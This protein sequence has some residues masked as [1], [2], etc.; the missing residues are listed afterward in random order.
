MA[1]KSHVVDIGD[2]DLL[3]PWSTVF[4]IAG[5]IDIADWVLVGGLMVQVHAYRAGMTLPRATKDL[6]LVVNVASLAIRLWSDRTAGRPSFRHRM[7]LARYLRKGLR[8]SSI[9]AT[10]SDIWRT[11]PCCSPALEPLEIS[12]SKISASTIVGG[13]EE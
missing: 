1:G 5:A 13:C 2:D 7:F 12:T 8:I 10:Q 4:E 6:D 3:P 11:L 9:S